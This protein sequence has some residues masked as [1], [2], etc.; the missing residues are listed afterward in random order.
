MSMQQMLFI[1]PPPKFTFLG[2][3]EAEGAKGPTAS[4]GAVSGTAS[5]DLQLLFAWQDTNQ[6]PT[7]T[8]SSGWTELGQDPFR[9]AL[10]AWYSTTD[11]GSVTVT[12]AP[13]TSG[14]AEDWNLVRLVFR[15]NQQ[16]NSI[17]AAVVDFDGSIGSYSH[18]VPS[19]STTDRGLYTY[20]HVLGLSGRPI[21]NLAQPSSISGT[22]APTLASNTNSDALSY[23]VINDPATTTLGT[24]T[25]NTINDSGRQ[26]SCGLW[27]AI[28]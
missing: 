28:R 15:P 16:I 26:S 11:T 3:D 17:T 13:F 25:Y 20:I 6:S 12:G 19:P 9:P 4:I 8:A 1:P 27:L 21:D 2:L 14:A 5:G 22:P 7:L 10:G 24:Y 23:Y 18:A